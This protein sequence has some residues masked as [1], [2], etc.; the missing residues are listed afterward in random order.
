MGE[1]F[2][3]VE[4]GEEIAVTYRNGTPIKLVTVDLQ[5]KQHQ[6]MSG[7]DALNDMS[8]GARSS[9]ASASPNTGMACSN[10]IR[11]GAMVCHD[12]YATFVYLAK[13]VFYDEY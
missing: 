13:V 5:A 11:A 4:G 3:R 12:K 9:H 1:I 7:L 2:Q 8:V 10:S 6:P